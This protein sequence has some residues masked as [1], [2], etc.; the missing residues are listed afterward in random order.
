MWQAARILGYAPTADYPEEALRGLTPE[1]ARQEAASPR[2]RT[3]RL[4]VHV[5]FLD[6]HN[7]SPMD[8]GWAGLVLSVN[9]AKHFEG[10]T[11]FAAAV[12]VPYG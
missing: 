7:A 10:P 6:G 11:C 12:F 2:R 9:Y 4:P 3:P 5:V 8:D 1:S